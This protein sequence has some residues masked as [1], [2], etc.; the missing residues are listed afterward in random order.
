MELTTLQNYSPTY[1]DLPIY[2][3]YSST[4]DCNS[5][6]I[7]NSPPYLTTLQNITNSPGYHLYS[8]TNNVINSD[9]PIYE[10]NIDNIE[11]DGYRSDYQPN[12][13]YIEKLINVKSSDSYSG[14]NR[15]NPL[16]KSKRKMCK[17]EKRNRI[18][19]KFNHNGIIELDGGINTNIYKRRRLAANARERRRMSGLN[20]AFNRLREVVPSLGAEQKLS[21]FET[22][23]MAQS[24][25]VAL[26]DLLEHGADETTY[27]L[28]NKTTSI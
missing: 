9:E 1:M 26:C 4:D 28:F 15:K 14:L 5:S 18:N 20:E 7:S 27:S 16:N 6:I 13:I 8:W 25:I 2:Q 11:N 19:G 17:S 21:K 3:S 22:L 24:Y 23:Q 10:Q 12:E